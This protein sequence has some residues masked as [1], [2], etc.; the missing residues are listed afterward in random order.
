MFIRPVYAD[1]FDELCQTHTYPVLTVEGTPGIGKSLMIGY[2]IWR[3]MH[4]RGKG[5]P[6]RIL[7]YGYSEG[8][9]LIETKTMRVFQLPEELDLNETDWILVDGVVN[10]GA[11]KLIGLGK[12]NGCKC[13]AFISPRK[14][15]RALL[16]NEIHRFVMPVWNYEEIMQCHGAVYQWTVEKIDARKR[17]GQAGGVARYVFENPDWA[18]INSELSKLDPQSI[19]DYDCELSRVLHIHAGETYQ[20]AHCVIEIASQEVEEYV[21]TKWQKATWNFAIHQ[22]FYGIRTGKLGKIFEKIGHK[23]I[24][25]ELASTGSLQLELTSLEFTKKY[26]W[27]RLHIRTETLPK[28]A[29]ENFLELQK[30]KSLVKSARRMVKFEGIYCKPQNKALAAVD[31]IVLPQDD[32]RRPIFLQYTIAE[33]HSLKMFGVMQIWNEIKHEFAFVNDNGEEEIEFPIFYFVIPNYQNRS[34]KP[35]TPE[36]SSGAEG[37]AEKKLFEN[38]SFGFLTVNDSKL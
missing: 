17:F 15:N 9:Y 20:F 26:E 1:L 29:R 32:E 36:Y 21:L 10:D 28:T 19:L 34:F 12:R 24:P 6:S 25:Q 14:M 2:I 33:T 37:R 18:S 4:L 16:T 11:A 38:M 23:L 27:R 5:S 31:A 13:V 22:V 7:V 35:K 3:L 30:L 8:G